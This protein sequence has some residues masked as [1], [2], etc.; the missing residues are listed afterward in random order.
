MA[1]VE[2]FLD[3]CVLVGVELE[4]GDGAGAGKKGLQAVNGGPQRSMFPANEEL[5]KVE[6][7]SGM[8][9][10]RRLKETL[11]S[12]SL[13]VM[14][15]IFPE[16]LLCSRK[17]PVR[18]VKLLTEKGICPVKLLEERS[19]RVSRVRRVRLGGNSPEN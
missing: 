4:E 13:A 15:G 17:R 7:V 11:K 18:W 1:P 2:S 8:E 9:P 6:S 19:K 12:T 16:K 5:G 3:L 14:L 10:L